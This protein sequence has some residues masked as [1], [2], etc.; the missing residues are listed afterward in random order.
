[1]STNVYAKFRCALQR[2]KKALGIL[3]NWFQHQQ[4]EELQ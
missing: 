1:M 3:E 4:K 2:I